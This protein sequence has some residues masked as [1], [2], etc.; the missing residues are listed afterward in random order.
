M[1]FST[2]IESVSMSMGFNSLVAIL[3]PSLLAAQL[4]RLV[5]VLQ[6]PVSFFR[7]LPFLLVVTSCALRSYFATSI[8][9]QTYTLI[10]YQNYQGSRETAQRINLYKLMQTT[11]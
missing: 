7:A 9:F 1:T 8:L 4:R 10:N 3:V 5:S 6:Q 11:K 2:E